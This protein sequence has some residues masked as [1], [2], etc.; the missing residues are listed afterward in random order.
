MLFDTYAW[1]ELF[2]GTDEGTQVARVL[3]DTPVVYTAPI[4]LAEVY[5]KIS[6]VKGR[7]E[8]E[9]ATAKI[10]DECASIETDASIS[11][12]AGRIHAEMKQK[13]PDFGMAD[14]FILACARDRGVKVLT[15]DPHFKDIE[16]A[17]ML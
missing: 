8:A 4:V 14:A 9:E 5:S 7:A 16:D 17:V 3:E 1:V 11:L 15:G 10:L 2:D 12:A 13:M 6:R